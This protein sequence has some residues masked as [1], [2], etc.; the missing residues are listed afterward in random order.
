M[1]QTAEDL[2]KEVIQSKKIFG[3][4][5][6]QG[7]L[8]NF[9]L[10]NVK[11]YMRKSFSVFTNPEYMPDKKITQ[12]A[13]KW[14]LENVVKN[15]DLKESAKTLKTSKMTD[16][17]AQNAFAESL[18]NK[19]LTHTKQDG[20]DPLKLLQQVSKNQLRSDKLIKTGEELPDAIKRLLG[21]EDNL[22][23]SVLQTTSHAITQSVNKQ[24]YDALAKIGI[25]EGWLYADEAAAT[26]ARAF[27]AVKVGE[28]KGLGILKA[29]YLN[30]MLQKIWQEL[31]K[32][33]WN[34]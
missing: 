3:E 28:L 25:E 10:N 30:Y 23:A 14:I 17:Q 31:Y 5:L 7:D 18:M 29:T 22:K 16:A 26:A 4:L 20:I 6:P 21:E 33:C 19:I 11:T 9:I 12:G 8:K 27:D 1:Q 13:T 34:F 2:N 15:K 24:T 32:V